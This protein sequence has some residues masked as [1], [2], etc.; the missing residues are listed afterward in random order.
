MRFAIGAS[1]IKLFAVH[2]LT[3]LCKLDHFNT[4]Y[5]YFQYSEMV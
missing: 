1:H 5:N 3:L 4:M 2:L